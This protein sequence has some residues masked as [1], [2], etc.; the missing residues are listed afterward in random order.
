[1]T[2]NTALINVSISVLIGS[3]SAYADEVGK[4]L[5]AQMKVASGGVTLDRR[6]GFHETGTL[7]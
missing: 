3:N 5:T 7:T 6:Q 2:G 4:R 1:M